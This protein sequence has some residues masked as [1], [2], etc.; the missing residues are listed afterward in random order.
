M[1]LPCYQAT[2]FQMVSNHLLL[3]VEFKERTVI[4]TGLIAPPFV[5]REWGGSSPPLFVVSGCDG[6]SPLYFWSFKKHSDLFYC[7]KIAK[8]HFLG[9]IL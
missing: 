8:M 6:P 3:K 4:V 1:H 2:L 5:G 9:T 7:N